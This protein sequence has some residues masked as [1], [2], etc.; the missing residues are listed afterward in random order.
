MLTFGKRVVPLGW[1]VM[2]CDT[3][4]SLVVSLATRTLVISGKPVKCCTLPPRLR[5]RHRLSNPAPPKDSRI[6]PIALA[7]S[8]VHRVD[9][10]CQTQDTHQRIG[11]LVRDAASVQHPSIEVK[12]TGSVHFR[13]QNSLPQKDQVVVSLARPR[14]EEQFFAQTIHGG[15]LGYR[16][17]RSQGM[18]EALGQV[19]MAVGPVEHPAQEPLRIARRL[20]DLPNVAPLNYMEYVLNNRKKRLQSFEAS[21]S[22]GENVFATLNAVSQILLHKF[23]KQNDVPQT[24]APTGAVPGNPTLA[25]SETTPA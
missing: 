25:Q 16:L 13:A 6:N 7:Q 9:Q 4:V 20:L 3:C 5:I 8:S 11:F 1:T 22:T 24:I 19:R 14:T 21:S 12:Q 17:V 2:L 23:S 10:P 15:G 18:A